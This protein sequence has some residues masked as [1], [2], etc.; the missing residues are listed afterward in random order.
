MASIL[1]SA[2]QPWEGVQ[3]ANLRDLNSLRR[4]EQICFP[5]DAW[6][7]LDLIGVLS[8][9]NIV[10]L[11]AVDA[12]Q[13]VGFI[14]ADVRRGQNIAWIATVGVLPEYRRRGVA[15]ALLAACEGRLKVGTVRLSV[16][17]SNEAAIQ[18]YKRLSYRQVG[19]W[20]AYYADGEDALVF[21]KR[22]DGQDRL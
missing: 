8:M 22:L 13:L 9:P 19:S 4:L 6:P 10:R 21:E 3:P 17:A 15:T 18:L 2:S 20:Q 12:D 1:T 16:R 14:A 5:K 7:L 11:K